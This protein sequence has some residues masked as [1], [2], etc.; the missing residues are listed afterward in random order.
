LPAVVAVVMVIM[1]P[2]VVAVARKFD[3][4]HLISRLEASQSP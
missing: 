2:V 3:R 4:V 1:L